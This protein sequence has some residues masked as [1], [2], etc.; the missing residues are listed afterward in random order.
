[1]AP[2]RSYD[3]VIIGAGSAGCVLAHRLSEDPDRR[4]LLLE[5]GPEDKAKEVHIPPAFVKLFKTP[6]DWAFETDPEP[7][8]H[9]RRLF[10]PRGKMLGGSS[11]LNAM[12]YVRGHR[13]DY[14]RWASDYGC[15]GWSFDE[16][17]PYFLRSQNQ[18]RGA[19]ALHGVDGPLDVQER[20]YVN[21]L[22]ERFLGACAEQGWADNPDF[23]GPSQEGFGVYQ[24]TQRQG[25]RCSTA[26]AFLNPARKRPNLTI[27]TGALVTRIGLE[28]GRARR[29][30][31]I[32]RGQAVT[33]HAD[34]EIVLSG[35][36]I[37]S[38]H[39]L[40]L[41][42]IG[43][44][45][46]L[47]EA[48]LDVQVDLPGVGANLQ[49]HPV[50]PVVFRSKKDLGLDNAET[51]VNLV[52][53]L[54]FKTGPLTTTVCEGGAF[55]RSRPELAQPDLQFHFI[56]AA[57][58]DHGFDQAA[59]HGFNFNP[60]VIKPKSRG[61]ICLR[62]ADPAQAPRI[63]A[64]YYRD[65]ADLDCMIEGVRLARRLAKS[66]AFADVLDRP[67]WP[68][69]DDD[70]REFIEDFVRRRTATLYHPACTCAMGPVS[71][72]DAPVQTVVGPDLKVHGVEGLR[73]ADA[74]V[75]PELIGGNTNAPT[76]MV[77]EKASDWIRGA[78][79]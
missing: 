34:Q 55:V 39:V 63:E 50:T 21:P 79:S 45:A 49:D 27:E 14:D 30:D 4:V 57:L 75:M 60:T 46:D 44:A 16:V 54:L 78:A 17:L 76:I 18:Q 36:A 52:R 59:D 77:A 22:T 73:V 37:G 1:M 65:G 33:F 26:V 9:H 35:G 8:C 7:E 38:P 31:A 3:V 25:R 67:A 42:G 56:P 58:V 2:T 68:D 62:S 28:N 66:S 41:S 6:L 29:V 12:L 70:S 13:R 20:R 11:S 24:V 15:D 51:L 40:L 32:Q 53:Y 61:R 69:C 48:G 43:P 19:S 10:W 71:T 64:G 47:Q 74:S 23:N 5:A 72:R